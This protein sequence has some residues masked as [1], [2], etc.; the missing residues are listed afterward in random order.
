MELI[1]HKN[2]WYVQSD[3]GY[4]E[5]L[6]TTDKSLKVVNDFD[7][8]RGIL[9]E[10]KTLPQPSQAFIKK[11]CE[12]GGIDEVLIEYESTCDVKRGDCCCSQQDIDCQCYSLKPKIDSYNT[13]TIHPI[14]P[15]LYTQEE[16]EELLI[17]HQS[18][19]RSHVRSKNDWSMDIK[20]W[21]TQNL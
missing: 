10:T 8:G 5:V 15:K 3:T 9:R 13:I 17:K 19:Y 20:K 6:A 12:V 11:Y 2:K 16:V 1:Q 14:E 21:I 4:R 7:T 18:D